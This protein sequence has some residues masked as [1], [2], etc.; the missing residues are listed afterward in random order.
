MTKI[1]LQADLQSFKPTLGELYVVMR[2]PRV[3]SPIL[4]LSYYEQDG[5]MIRRRN[6]TAV[7]DYI[8]FDFRLSGVGMDQECFVECDPEIVGIQKASDNAILMLVRMWRDGIYGFREL[9]EIWKEAEHLKQP[10]LRR[11]E[12]IARQE[13][14]LQQLCGQRR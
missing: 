10:E 7:M 13:V 9:V 2:L 5:R 1:F 12:N 14:Q 6:L 3:G 11:V 8:A 4:Q